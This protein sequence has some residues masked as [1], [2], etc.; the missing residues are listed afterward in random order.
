MSDYSLVDELLYMRFL[1]YI[2]TRSNKIELSL[3]NISIKRLPVNDIKS[4]I[5]EKPLSNLKPEE[6]I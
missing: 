1:K 4:A 2:T 3:L 6:I 5:F